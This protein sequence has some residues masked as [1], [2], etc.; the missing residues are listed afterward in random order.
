MGFL[1]HIQKCA[2]LF[3]PNLAP[4]LNF[5]SI[6]FCGKYSSLSLWCLCL[7]FFSYLFDIFPRLCLIFFSPV[8]LRA[9]WLHSLS[10]PIKALSLSQQC[11][12]FAVKP[13]CNIFVM[14][15]CCIRVVLSF[16]DAQASLAPTHLRC[17]S[18]GWSNFRISNRLASLVALREKLKRQDPND[19]LTQKLF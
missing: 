1:F 10:K 6:S 4:S 13:G 3:S 14:F 9:L 2:F 5:L 7:I 11:R 15:L 8:R 19:F 16:L 18:V 12:F 17:P